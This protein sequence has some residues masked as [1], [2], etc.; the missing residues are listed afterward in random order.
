MI[1]WLKRIVK[2]IIFRFKFKNVKFRKKSNFKF[3]SIFKGY[4]VLG[5]NSWF[6]GVIGKFSYIGENCVISAKIGNFCS[7][8]NNV[9]TIKGT[10]PTNFISTSPVFYS[11]QK[12]CG[13]SFVKKNLFDESQQNPFTTNIGNDVWIG[14]GV[15]I[16]NGVSIG[17][18]AIIGTQSVVTKDVPE[19]SIVAGIPAKVIRY[20][21]TDEEIQIIKNSKWWEKDNEW[22][23]KYGNSFTTI[24]ELKNL[25][26]DGIL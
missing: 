9:Y 5:K 15:T 16:L 23:Y 6:E 12:Q 7:I 18:G 10:H 25:I 22:F 20:R 14:Y 19:Y 26:K 4:N 11:T 8:G 21:F 3:S 24:D 1:L 2:K 13:I 17:N